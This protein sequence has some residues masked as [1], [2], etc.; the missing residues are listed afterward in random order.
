MHSTL[1]LNSGLDTHLMLR[2]T[3]V[4]YD[5]IVTA[6]WAQIAERLYVFLSGLH[7]DL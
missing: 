2:C 7:V 6:S 4:A 3:K 5:L 1:V